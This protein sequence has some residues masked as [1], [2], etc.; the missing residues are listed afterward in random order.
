[1]FVRLVLGHADIGITTL[2]APSHVYCVKI[3]FPYYEK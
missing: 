3:Q 1:M 2:A